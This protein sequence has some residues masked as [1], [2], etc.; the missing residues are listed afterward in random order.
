MSFFVDLNLALAPH[1]KGRPRF[2]K[3]GTTYTD[4]KTAKHEAQIRKAWINRHGMQY[5]TILCPVKVRIEFETTL[6]K[7]VSKKLQ[8]LGEES[9]PW[10]MRNAGDLDNLAKSVLDALNGVAYYDDSQIVGLEAVKLPQS[11]TSTDAIRV[12]IEYQ[13]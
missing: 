12:H 9:R 1:P 4:P 3:A 2:S 7:T 8:K 11:V 13:D 10:T 5:S 6:P